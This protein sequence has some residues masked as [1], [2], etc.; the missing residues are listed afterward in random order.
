MLFSNL[1]RWAAPRATVS[2]GTESASWELVR[3]GEIVTQVTD[4][5]VA[6]AETEYGMAGVKWYA[7]GMFH[8]ETVLGKDMSA[9]Y[10]TPLKPGALVYNRLFAWKESFAV[11]TPEHDGLFVSN[12]FPQFIPDTSRVLPEFLF[13]FC[14]TPS[15]TRLVNAASAGSAAV[16]RNRFKE[17]EFTSFELRLP[18]LAT[19]Q[20]IIAHWRKAQ[21]R[22]DSTAAQYAAVSD[23]L[24]NWLHAHSNPKAFDGH[25]LRVGW[26]GLENWT[27]QSARAAVFRQTNPDFVPFR[28]YAEESTEMVKPSAEPDHEWPVYGVNNKDGVFFSHLQKGATF[29]SPYKRIKKDWFFHNPTRS[30]VGSLGHVLEVP[31]DAITSPEYQVWKLRDL[32]EKSLLPAFV[33]TLIQTPWFVKVIQFHRVG[34]VKQRLY[35]ENLLSMPVPVFP[36]A[37]QERVTAARERIAEERA[38]AAKLAADT[39][40]EV[41]EMILGQRPAPKTATH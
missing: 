35:V 22:L 28:K 15:T 37:L 14:T 9:R 36:R 31:S 5:L 29:N 30:A 33:A 4:K 12:E 39:A 8:R 17:S 19:Q 40:R 10:V 41:E 26:S 27:V 23:E 13:L 16:S 20:A 11:V 25:C 24:D 1:D 38:A 32:G 3:V 34:A 2:H 6:D 21:D 18:P 7:G